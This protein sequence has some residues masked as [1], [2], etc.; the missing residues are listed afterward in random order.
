[1]TAKRQTKSLFFCHL[2]K[3]QYNCGKPKQK[4]GKEKIYPK[5]NLNCIKIFSLV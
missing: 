3:R 4:F 2:K 5:P 1:M